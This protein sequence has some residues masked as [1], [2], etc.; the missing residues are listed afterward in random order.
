METQDTDQPRE[1]RPEATDPRLEAPM[2]PELRWTVG[3]LVG[4]LA[5]VGTLILVGLVA[6]ALSPPVWMQVV[7]GV[8]LACGGAILAWLVAEA[9]GHHHRGP[10]K[11]SRPRD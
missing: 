9:L 8:G 4:S 10:R 7:L 5:T 1:P 3:C 2:P 11:R 6:I